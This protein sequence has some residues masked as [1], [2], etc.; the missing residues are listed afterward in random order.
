MLIYCP[1]RGN[2][3]KFGFSVS[4]KFGCAV[5]RNRV[6]RQL[7][8]CA[9]RLLPVVKANYTYIFIPKFSAGEFA[10]LLESMRKLLAGADLLTRGTGV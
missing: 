10:Q 1:H 4:A 7:K 8:E 6:R 2:L 9:T 3:P 5:R